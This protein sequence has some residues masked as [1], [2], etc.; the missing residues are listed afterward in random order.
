MKDFSGSKTDKTIVRI[1]NKIYFKH[2]VLKSIR[3][4]CDYCDANQRDNMIVNMLCA[5]CES[6]FC[7]KIGSMEMMLKDMLT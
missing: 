1:N 6:N 5:N 7:Y 2:K 4:D 3:I